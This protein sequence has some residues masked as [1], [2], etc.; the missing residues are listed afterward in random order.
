MIRSNSE[1][2]TEALKLGAIVEAT[3]FFPKR[4]NYHE[5]EPSFVRFFNDDLKE[6]CYYTVPLRTL[7]TGFEEP[8]VW[9]DV[10]LAD[11]K[12]EAINS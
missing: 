12:L 4:N 1:A 5:P 9:S 11:L 8:R 6:V 10:F 7:Y 3:E 2:R